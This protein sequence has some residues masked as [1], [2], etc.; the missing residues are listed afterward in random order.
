VI[1][2]D[3]HPGLVIGPPKDRCVIGARQPYLIDVHRIVPGR[4]QVRR[5]AVGNILIQQ[6]F[7]ADRVIGK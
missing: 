5:D 3:N 6:K 4:L 7:H 2:G 1:V